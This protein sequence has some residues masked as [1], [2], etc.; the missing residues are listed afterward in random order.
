MSDNDTKEC[1]HC[2][3]GYIP[4]RVKVCYRCN[5]DLSILPLQTYD[6]IVTPLAGSRFIDLVSDDEGPDC[7]IPVTINPIVIGGMGSPLYSHEREKHD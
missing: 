6:I 4:P 7:P 1:P 5:A 3:A 2:G